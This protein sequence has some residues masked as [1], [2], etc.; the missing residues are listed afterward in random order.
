MNSAFDI[1]LKN[2]KNNL[3]LRIKKHLPYYIFILP[4]A[5]YLIVFIYVPMYGIQIAFRNY[6][7][8]LGI[9]GSRWV[10]L[11]HVRDFMESFFFWRVVRNTLTISIYSFLA[12]FPIPI[13]LALVLNEIK[14]ML[15]KRT[16]QT[17]MYAP[18]FIST[19]VMCGM[20][21][22]FLSPSDGIINKFLGLFGME[23]SHYIQSG[24]TWKHI[25]VWSGVWQMMGWNAIIYLA[26]LSNVDPTHYE[27]A[28]IDGAIRIQKI[29]HIN[30]P[31]IRPTITIILILAIGNLIGVGFEKA[32]LL[33]NPL[34]AEYSEVIATFIYKRAFA[35]ANMGLVGSASF[36]FA[37]A[38]GLF[39]S[40]VNLFLL[41]L[42][43]A[44]ARFVGDTS[45]F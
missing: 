43:N 17:I 44:L 23:P 6:N 8:A 37:A 10:G 9:L 35:S 39:N 22:M 36:S 14:H 45:L 33:Q 42:A 11:R 32:Y 19:V 4:T 7:P 29:W 21:L 20:I 5:I 3:A 30:L 1:K 28:T 2:N 31:I 38:I 15:Y 12:G 40:L 16:L 34:N 25:F 18:Y 41:L 26:A 24:P 27:A 13:L